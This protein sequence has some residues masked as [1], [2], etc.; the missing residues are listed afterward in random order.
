[1]KRVPIIVFW[2]LLCVP[3]LVIGAVVFRLLGHEGERLQDSAAEALRARVELVAGELDLALRDL[4]EGVTKQLAGMDAGRL[5]EELDAW[6]QANPL[7]RNVFIVDEGG[8]IL[9]PDPAGPLSGEE[10][11]FLQRF[12]SLFSGREPWER[13]VADASP[14]VPAPRESSYMARRAFRQLAAAAPAKL[15]DQELHRS[16]WLPWFSENQLHL[17]G[18]LRRGGGATYGAEIEMT[19]LLSRLAPLV[20][21]EAGDGITLALR[22]GSGRTLVQAGDVDTT[23]D[24]QPLVE[25]AATPLAPHWSVAAFGPVP[26]AGTA[27]SF[28]LM[29]GLLVVIFVASIVIGGSLLL[30]QAHAGRRDAAQKTTFVSN[31]SHELKTPLT[32]IRMYAELLADGRVREEEKRSDYLRVIIEQAQRLARLVNNVLDFSRIEQNR[33]KYNIEPL[34]AREALVRILETQQPRFDEAGIRLSVT[35]P[36]EGFSAAL[37]RDAFEQAVLNLADNAIKYAA[38]GKELQVELASGA[39]GREVRF[40][41]RGPGVPASHR[42]RLF[43]KFHRVDDSLT[44]RQPGTGLGL[45]IARRMMRDMGGDVFFEPRQGGGS[46]FI[47]RLPE[48]RAS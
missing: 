40:L 25:V 19:A 34:D 46:C 28:V 37:D 18:W 48:G 24:V 17:L 30:W 35:G 12:D 13:P 15:A 21:S 36:A 32:T 39:Q 2:L 44:S 11:M 23:G 7:I 22:D 4:E 42:G 16:G 31:V 43:Q 45:S 9:L 38:E 10:R 41:D 8:R 26:G 1:M 6:A 33:K 29:G 14:A 5:A 47:L 20:R 27:R 3:A